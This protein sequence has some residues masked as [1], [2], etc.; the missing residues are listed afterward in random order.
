M[1][2][3]QVLWWIVRTLVKCKKNYKLSV[4]GSLMPLDV[5]SEV[6]EVNE[7][8]YDMLVIVHAEILE[9]S[10]CFTLGVVQSKVVS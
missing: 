6:V 4:E 2:L 3:V 9:V 10:L 7:V 8:L 5:S 1:Y